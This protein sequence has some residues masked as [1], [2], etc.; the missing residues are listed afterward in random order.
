MRRVEG[1]KE[2]RHMRR[3]GMLAPAGLLTGL[4]V[5]CTTMVFNGVTG[6]GPL[7]DEPREVSAFSAVEAGGG[8][9]VDLAIGDTQSVVV[10]TNENLLPVIE[11]EVVGGRLVI[12]GRESYSAPQGVRVTIVVPELTGITLSGGATGQVDG[13]DASQ[14]AV[15]LSG[16]AQLA[17]SGTAASLRLEA[18]G[19]AG[20]HL[21][22]LHLA[23]ADVSLSGGSQA[24]LHAS[25]RVAGD[26]S[27]GS[28]LDVA[29]GGAVDVETSGG[30]RVN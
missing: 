23:D 16:G 22:G 19:G 29:G 8:V 5:G 15:E 28:Q 2:T 30:S 1:K 13:L 14:L 18:S 4:L 26:C 10:R 7:A 20:A 27:G 12:S 25:G 11:T 21:D 6:E 9:R 3:I 17:A 24:Q